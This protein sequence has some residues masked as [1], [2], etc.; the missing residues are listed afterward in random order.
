MKNK[1]K[2]K[3]YPPSP[4]GNVC[5]LIGAEVGGR[6]GLRTLRKRVLYLVRIHFIIVM[7]RWTGLTPWE[8]EFPFPGSLTATFLYWR[9]ATKLARAPHPACWELELFEELE[10]FVNWSSLRK[11]GLSLSLFSLS[12]SFF[13]SHT[14]S[15]PFP[16]SLALSLSLTRSPSFSRALS[17]SPA[18]GA[19]QG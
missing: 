16:L 1:K 11:R 14:H 6:H 7:I 15:L 13:L 4:R 5:R 10:L 8:I 9:G 12:L 3:A 2:L 17:H 18:G 19:A